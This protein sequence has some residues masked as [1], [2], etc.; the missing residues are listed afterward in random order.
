M[1]N[2]IFVTS[3]ETRVGIRNRLKNSDAHRDRIFGILKQNF[4]LILGGGWLDQSLR[5]GG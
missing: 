1:T 3:P 5:V 2:I 4:K